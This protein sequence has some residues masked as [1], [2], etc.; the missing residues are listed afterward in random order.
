[1][2]AALTVVSTAILAAAAKYSMTYTPEGQAMHA[3]DTARLAAAST[4]NVSYVPLIKDASFQITG[5]EPQGDGTYP[6]ILFFTGTFTGHSDTTLLLEAFGHLPA[7][8]GGPTRH[9]P[10]CGFN[11][12]IVE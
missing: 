6:V 4:Y 7:Q 8:E 12:N 1:M 5:Y 11:F 10:A 9:L 3:L 2:L